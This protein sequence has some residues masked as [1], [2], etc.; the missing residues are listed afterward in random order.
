MLHLDLLGGNGIVKNY[1]RG[2]FVSDY[3]MLL[4]IR[5]KKS[6]IAKVIFSSITNSMMFYD[7]NVVLRLFTFWQNDVLVAL[8]G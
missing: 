3:V 4:I 7:E 5:I 8:I 6:R 1:G 2:Y